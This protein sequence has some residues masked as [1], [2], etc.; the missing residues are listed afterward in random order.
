[1][2]AHFAKFINNTWRIRIGSWN[3][4][5]R[6]RLLIGR[7]RAQLLPVL[8]TASRGTTAF[9]GHAGPSGRS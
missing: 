9:C 1:M 3:T 5:T 6:A 8:L 7:Q 4:D 2:E